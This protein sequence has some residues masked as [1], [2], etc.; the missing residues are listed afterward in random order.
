ML[1]VPESAG[2]LEVVAVVDGACVPVPPVVA[3]DEEAPAEVL[4]LVVA[5]DE[6]AVV[7][8]ELLVVEVVELDPEE[9]DAL[10]D[11]EPDVL[12]GGAVT[13]IVAV[14]AGPVS[15]PSVPAKVNESNPK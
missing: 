11:P 1:F 7:E 4:V 9:P 12:V 13:S 14:A 3:A 15:T 6:A 5:V 10:L 2:A 8:P